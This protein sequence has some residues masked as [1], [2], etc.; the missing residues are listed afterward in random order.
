MWSIKQLRIKALNGYTSKIKL[1]G[2]HK[3]YQGNSIPE[4]NTTISLQDYYQ[5]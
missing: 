3:I 5:C 2:F 1:R 4:N